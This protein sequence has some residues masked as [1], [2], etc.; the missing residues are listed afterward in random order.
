VAKTAPTPI[1][2]D[3]LFSPEGSFQRGFGIIDRTLFAGANQQSE[4][5]RL[6]TKKSKYP[7]LFL[8]R[9]EANFT[10]PPHPTREKIELR[11]TP[12]MART[13]RQIFNCNIESGLDIVTPTPIPIVNGIFAAP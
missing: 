7:E 12:F 10:Y 13:L 3:L 1:G 2:K 9:F 5:S 11:P 8:I 6:W 4:L